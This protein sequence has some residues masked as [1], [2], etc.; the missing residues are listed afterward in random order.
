MS[1]IYWLASYPKSGNTWLRVFLQNYLSDTDVP[2]DINSIQMGGELYDRDY[3]D[4]WLGVETS[5]MS[6]EQLDIA[7]PGLY[8]MILD[9][10]KFRYAKTHEYYRINQE[11][12]PV[13]SAKATAGAVLL[14]RNPFDVAVSLAHYLCISI[15]QAIVM[16]T[17]DSMTFNASE[18]VNL[19]HLPQ[20]IGGWSTHA[21]SWLNSGV[22]ICVK[23]YEDLLDDPRQHFSE[24]I[25]FLGIE[26][27][28]SRAQKALDFSSFDVLKGQEEQHGFRELQTG[29]KRF[30]DTAI[31][32]TGKHS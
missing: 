14:V 2:A 29:A 15:D 5:D 18:N 30:L 19:P 20:I 27:D 13:F 25:G 28:L 23:R 32:E 6:N 31:Q 11:G 24:I 4:D 7:R 10:S 21:R 3:L 12:V 1:G 8:E 17:D 26:L 22:R 16:M 9:S